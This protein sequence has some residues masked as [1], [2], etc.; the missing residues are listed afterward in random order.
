[1]ETATLELNA[2]RFLALFS[3]NLPDGMK[4]IA[5]ALEPH[6][7]FSRLSRTSSPVSDERTPSQITDVEISS[8]DTTIDSRL[9]S[10]WRLTKDSI[11]P[12]M[13]WELEN[14][15]NPEKNN[16]EITRSSL[17]P[18][19][20]ELLWIP[21][22]KGLD[23][24]LICLALPSTCQLWD[25]QPAGS[26]NVLRGSDLLSTDIDKQAERQWDIKVDAQDISFEGS[27]KANSSLEIKKALD[28]TTARLYWRRAN[29]L[30]V[31]VG[32]GGDGVGFGFGGGGSCAYWQ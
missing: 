30:G 12:E 2:D 6:V 28:D 29:G 22:L 9:N 4:E 1:M 14:R 25:Q 8:N 21:L 17:A 20:S 27:A 13:S 19:S 24:V 18:I 16:K 5:C 7:H 11:T 31:G 26:C 10:G 32:F 23:F 3:M 15:K